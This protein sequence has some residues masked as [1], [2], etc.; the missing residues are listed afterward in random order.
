MKYSLAVFDLDGTILDTLADLTEAAN[1]A[2]AQA[3]LPPHGADDVR[4]FIGGGVTNLIRRA[5]PDRER[6]QPF[7]P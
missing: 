2:L 3:G 1:F 7:R 6:G 5:V 4:R